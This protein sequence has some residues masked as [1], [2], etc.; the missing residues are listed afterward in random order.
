M[1]IRFFQ[2]R[3]LSQDKNLVYME[4]MS[5]E[6]GMSE[7]FITSIRTG[8]DKVNADSWQRQDTLLPSST[9]AHDRLG[10]VLLDASL[11]VKQQLRG[12]FIT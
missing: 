6:A 12:V 2:F 10:L 9:Q 11:R 8:T 5:A 7:Y 1:L 4:N 3:F